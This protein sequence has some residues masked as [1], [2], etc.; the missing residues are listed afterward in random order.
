MKNL[1]L[2]IINVLRYI[3]RF[4]TFIR[5][6]IL[7]ILF[8]LLLLVIIVPFLP[9]DYSYSPRPGVP[10]DS[11]V[12]LD[13]SGDLVE[14]KSIISSFEKLF[15]T[16]LFGS[17]Q[18]NPQTSMQE[19]LDIIKNAEKDDSIAAILLNLRNMGTAGL[20][21]LETIGAALTEFRKQGKLVIVADNLYTQ[22]RYFLASF[23]DTIVINPMGA[24]DIHGMGVYRLYFKDVIDKLK[25]NYNVFKVG[26]YKSALEPFTRTDMS[27]EDRAQNRLWLSQ[28]WNR[29]KATV[30]DNRKLDSKVIDSY[31]SNISELI[32]ATH[33]DT[34]QLALNLGLIDH[35]WNQ[36]ELT[37]YLAT[38]SQ[39]DKDHLRLVPGS[40]YMEH[41][42]PSFHDKPPTGS[43]GLIIA[44]GKIVPGKQ[45]AG[46]IG[47]QSLVELLQSARK[48]DRIKGLVLRIN[49]SGGSAFASEVIRQEILQ[50][51]K[52][53]KPIVVSMGSIAASGG[54]WIAAEADSIWAYSTTLTGSIGI[55]GAIP[56]FENSLSAL[57][58]YSD[59]V[60]TT[61]LAAGLNLTRPLSPALGRVIQNTVE[62]NYSMFLQ[63]VAKGRNISSRKVA[64][65][66]QGRV[67]DGV[68]AKKLG[69]VDNIG[70]LDDAL[71]AAAAMAGLA[72]T[73]VTIIEPTR[74]LKQQL[75]QLLSSQEDE[76]DSMA[77]VVKHKL[78]QVLETMLL[79]DDPQGVYAN[80]FIDPRL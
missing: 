24:V 17:P 60:G 73:S 71:E 12:R 22:S 44:E 7:N 10:A 33:G 53:G 80:C 74:S 76:F 1:L 68:T 5:N 66:A 48:D 65:L 18:N 55:F 11:I 37:S 67:Y 25:I 14:Q 2:A 63:I 69:L 75:I 27:E 8:F 40:S 30:A 15:T 49:S 59:G 29:Y 41:I 51:K 46:I 19:I 4:F 50:F 32:S 58:I 45:P 36:A 6:S 52:S 42:T 62:Y 56:T 9:V 16:S 43:I 26:S 34:A 35:I 57:G 20:G 21:Q 54:Y 64:D 38:I 13:I 3:G 72:Q 78:D 61:P 28:L 77:P 23:A 39:T 31:T 70:T 47:S 79:M